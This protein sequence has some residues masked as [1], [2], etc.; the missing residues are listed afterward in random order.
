MMHFV[1]EGNAL[2]RKTKEK[3]KQLFIEE[4]GG[5]APNQEEKVSVMKDLNTHSMHLFASIWSV[6]VLLFWC[7]MYCIKKNKDSINPVM[8]VFYKFLHFILFCFDHYTKK[9][10]C[11]VLSG[12]LFV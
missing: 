1:I 12:N 9:L 8:P 4:A 3:V 10:L 6:V 11:L 7:T 5:R 2:K